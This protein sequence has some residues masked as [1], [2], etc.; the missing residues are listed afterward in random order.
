MKYRYVFIVFLIVFMSMFIFKDTFSQIYTYN[1]CKDNCDYKDINTVID[2]LNNDSTIGDKTVIINLDNGDF[3]YVSELVNYPMNLI[4]NGNNSTNVNLLKDFNFNNNLTINNIDFNTSLYKFNFGN[5]NI[6]LNDVT[7]RNIVGNKDNSFVSI[8]N[9]T[10]R[11]NNVSIG[12]S[13]YKNG[14]YFYN[15]SN[16]IMN[17]V[18]CNDN[19]VD[20]LNDVGYCD[21]DINLSSFKNNN[22]IVRNNDTSI[23]SNTSMNKDSIKTANTSSLY[24]ESSILNNIELHG[25]LDNYPVSY[26]P[27]SNTWVKSINESI[28]EDNSFILVDKIIKENIELSLSSSRSL[29]SILDNVSSINWNTDSNIVKVSDSSILP[30]KKGKCKIIGVDNN[31]I[32]EINVKVVD[33]K[34]NLSILF[35]VLFGI[36]FIS[37]VTGLFVNRYEKKNPKIVYYIEDKI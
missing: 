8:S 27:Y 31:Y 15:C 10:V 20:V 3:N 17:D 23:K 25:L 30:L 22:I 29:S 5:G 18:V 14:L 1:V 11:F 24:I 33:K 21:I 34:V 13:D 4:I 36:I 6:I 32:Y 19:N 9:S 26:I 2:I 35:Y 37:F 7:F 12:K 16:V 28:L